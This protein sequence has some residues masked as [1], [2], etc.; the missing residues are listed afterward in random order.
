MCFLIVTSNPQDHPI[1]ELELGSGSRKEES[2]HI[3]HFVLHAALDQLDEHVWSQSG[4][5]F[6]SVDKFN[7]DHVTAH[8]TAGKRERENSKK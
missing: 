8:V 6:R 2:S 5:Y 1:Y 4:S 7:V 3:S